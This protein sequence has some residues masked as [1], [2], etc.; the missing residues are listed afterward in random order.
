MGNQRDL[1]EELMEMAKLASGKT[2]KEILYFFAIEFAR[3]SGADRVCLII[4]NLKKQLVIKA[5][6]PSGAHP[7]NQIIISEFGASFLK[8]VI[9][10]RKYVLINNPATNPK[11]SYMRELAKYRNITSI[12]FTPLYREDEPL[13]LLVFDF[14]NGKRIGRE[15]I[16]R[17][18]NLAD[19]M[20]ATMSAEY[21]KRRE[22]E[23]L[24]HKERVLA[25]GINA[26]RAAHRIRNSLTIIGGHTARIQKTVKKIVAK[27]LELDKALSLI[28]EY[29]SM[30]I[31]REG[32]LENIVKDILTFS[33]LPK[34]SIGRYN[35]NDFLR[36]EMGKLLTI[37]ESYCM[38]CKF[39]FDRRL[40]Y[41][42]V[43]CDKEK[44]LDCLRDVII[45][46]HEANAKFLSLKTRLEIKKN[47]VAILISNNGR[48]L[49]P[50]IGH[51]EI[52]EPFV[53]TK[54]N[55]TGMGLAKARMIMEAHN[56]GI[57][58]VPQQ[59]LSS[60]RTTFKIW[61]PFKR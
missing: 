56:G 31:S 46:A 37:N 38:R 13:G 4:Q 25:L 19:L 26:A 2:Y 60:A 23:E 59:L 40:D 39:N 44:I 1:A 5:G 21:E 16:R 7:V 55:G 34:L 54:T 9:G 20:S 15:N 41:V 3:I 14:L 48:G 27:E 17:I 6:F 53:T 61:F 58:L 11:T 57:K 42:K 24:R 35:L 28:D 33:F 43:F 50:N 12:L 51:E 10:Y 52:F 49:D 8:Q 22:R 29:A 45:N 36:E 18:L 30:V 47:R 32:E